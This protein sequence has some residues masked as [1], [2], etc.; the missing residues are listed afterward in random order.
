[1]NIKEIARQAGVSVATVSRVLNHPETVAPKTRERILDL[2]EQMDYK[3]NWFARGLNFNKTYTLAL[4]IPNILNPAYV[5]IAEG[6]ES[7]ANRKGYS[8]LLCITEGEVE[9]ERQY[10]Q[11][12]IDRHIDGVILV[13]SLLNGDDIN[14]LKQQGV[15]VVL[16]GENNGNSSEPMVRIDCC[17]AA[18]QAV[19]HLLNCGHRE[20]ALVYGHT[21]VMENKHKIEGYKKAL[22]EAGIPLRPEYLVEEQNTEEGGYLAT[23][24]LL[25]LKE[26]PRAIFTTSD[27]LAFGVI[28]ALRDAELNIPDDVAVMGF[29]N[30]RMAKL[31]VPKLSTVA[32]PLH[33]M[34]LSSARL[35]LD[36]IESQGNGNMAMREIVLQSKLKIR[37]SCGHKERI[38]EIF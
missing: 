2:M 36:V 15:A 13:S 1:M 18:Y 16:V 14:Y 37:K 38:K 3:P 4:L 34:G 17:A 32:K 5:E 19:Q 27:L 33:K 25:G 28:D 9:K 7:V 35:L 31:M 22:R 29:D 11:T 10:I 6:V 30:I 24:K 21:P 8:V 20:I 12:L 23:R 26:R